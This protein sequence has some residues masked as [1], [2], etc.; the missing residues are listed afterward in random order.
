MRYKY[1]FGLNNEYMENG[2]IFYDWN[3]DYIVKQPLY[4]TTDSI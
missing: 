2:Q 3:N 4:I 1:S